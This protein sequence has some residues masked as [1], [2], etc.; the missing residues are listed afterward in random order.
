MNVKMDDAFA[1]DLRTALVNHVAASSSQRTRRARRGL[2][3]GA[4][5]AVVLLGGGVAVASGGLTLPGADVVTPMAQPVTRTGTGNGTVTL[6]V[7]PAGSTAIDIQLTCLSAGTFY[8]EDGANLVCDAGDAGSGTMNWRI[9]LRAGQRQ[10]TIRAAA[11]EKWRVVAT[12]ADVSTS[13]WGTNADGLTF[14]VANANGTPDLLAVIATNG[15]QGYVYSRDLELPSPTELQTGSSSTGPLRL[16]V[17]E[18]DG[19]TVIGEFITNSLPSGVAVP[20]RSAS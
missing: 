8:T 6:G 13:Q 5:V 3:L 2:A 16:P 19:H 10:T 1:A 9:P 17:Y 7:P 18:S 4:G 15:K 11:G 20:T 12:Y 14:G